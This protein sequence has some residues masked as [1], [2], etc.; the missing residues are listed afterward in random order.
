MAR[1]R[2]KRRGRIHF[3]Q[4]KTPFWSHSYGILTHKLVIDGIEM[5]VMIWTGYENTEEQMGIM[6]L[7]KPLPEESTYCM[8]G[9]VQ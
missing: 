2:E 8:V 3:F 1:E 4:T 7:A 5:Q 9:D 6:Q